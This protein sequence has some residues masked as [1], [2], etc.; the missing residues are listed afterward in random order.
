MVKLYGPGL[1][2][3]LTELE[4]LSKTFEHK[5]N[6]R[7]TGPFVGEEADYIILWQNY[8]TPEET[9]AL[10]KHLDLT[11]AS[12]GCKYSVSTEPAK[13]E[14]VFEQIEASEAEDLALTFVRLIGPS[15]SQA[16]E[17]LN[18]HIADFPGIKPLPGE[19]IGRYDYAFEWARI[20]DVQDIIRLSEI[21]D[22]L[23]GETGAFYNIATKSKLKRIQP[24]RETK[25]LERDMDLRREQLQFV[26]RRFF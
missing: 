20:P 21:M 17:V 8:P 9:L 10:V 13:G 3:A 1:S 12:C 5:N 4:D 15:I 25:E 16:I 11:F 14:D 2:N 7:Y 22:Q 6:I 26:V 23:L 19:L 24:S 18:K